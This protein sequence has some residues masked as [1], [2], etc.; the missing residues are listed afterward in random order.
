MAS[1][2]TSRLGGMISLAMVAGDLIMIN[3]AFVLAYYLRYTLGVG[4]EVEEEFFVTIN[5]YFPI[6]A[7]LTAILGLVYAVSGLYRPRP[8][9]PLLKTMMT[10]LAATSVG[11]MLVL[12]IVFLYQGYAYSR[13]L[14]FFTWALT[15]LLLW[16]IRGGR[17]ALLASLRRRGLG[18]RRALVVGSDNLSK[19][20]MHVLATEAN[21]GYQLI[22]FVGNDDDNDMGR[23]KYLG[24]MEELATLVREKDIHEVIIALPA[25]SHHQILEVTEHCRREKVRFKMVPDLFEMSLG[26][27]D[28]DDLRGIP[29]IG[30]EEAGIQGM[31]LFFKRTFDLFFTIIILVIFAPFWGIIALL[32]KLDSPGPILFKQT[33]VGKGG[34]LFEAYKFRSMKIDAEKQMESLAGQNEATWPLFKIKDDPRITRVGRF[35]RRTSL[36]E[37]PQLLNVLQGEMSL[38]GPRPPLPAEVEQYQEWHK[39]RLEITPGITGLWQVSGR[40]DLPFDEMVMLDIYYINNWSLALDFLTLIRTIP[41]VITGRGA[42]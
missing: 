27:T 20:V 32:I 29:L 41:A 28:I 25:S 2:T 42:Y 35:L 5:A 10:V 34:R 16:L 6:Q 1:S 11:M 31:G 19:M 33:R 4:G 23:F 38:I 37:I 24:G 30:I 7:A 13:W 22:G 17:I 14:F 9:L 12:A 3:A 40:S 21:L 39:R 36:D 15:V 26:K 8:R 18:V